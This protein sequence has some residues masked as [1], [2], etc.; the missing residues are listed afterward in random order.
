MVFSVHKAVEK[1]FKN[2]FSRKLIQF[3]RQWS[4]ICYGPQYVNIG[5]MEFNR[6]CSLDNIVFTHKLTDGHHRKNTPK[7]GWDLKNLNQ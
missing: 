5:Q 7:N 2:A 1:S 6:N 4:I 3:L